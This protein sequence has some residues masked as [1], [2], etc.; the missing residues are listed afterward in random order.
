MGGEHVDL[1]IYGSDDRRARLGVGHMVARS[2]RG[3]GRHRPVRRPAR[4]GCTGHR[5]IGRTETGITMD[6]DEPIPE[7]FPAILTELALPETD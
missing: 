2:C 6:F 1:S 3:A 7:T 5:R 4:T